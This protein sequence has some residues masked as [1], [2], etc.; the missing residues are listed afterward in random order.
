MS[1]PT[2]QPIAAIPD[3]QTELET[4]R[5]V[6]AELLAKSATRKAKIAE[7]EVAASAL[8][9]KLTESE[10]T[11]HELSVTR[12]LKAMAES[13]STAPDVFLEHLNK[14]YRIEVL[15]GELSL[16]T[17]DGKPVLN[18]DNA[19]PFT[20]EGLTAL[21]SNPAHPQA[22]LF[23]SILIVSKASGASGNGFGVV[24]KGRSSE[25][26]A[27]LKRPQFGLR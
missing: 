16:L 5:R 26:Q 10:S 25:T 3:M 17:S 22:K 23:S 6:N 14:S 4:L 8:Q 13:I 18:G 12:P 1:E 20:G 7:L 11:I 24:R 2:Q 21:L 9:G 19:V 27:P 15:K